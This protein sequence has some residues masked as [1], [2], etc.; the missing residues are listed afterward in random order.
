MVDCYYLLAMLY[1]ERKQMY[2]KKE[3]ESL[4]IMNCGYDLKEGCTVVFIVGIVF[5][6]KC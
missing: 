1:S 3:I 2:K 4:L 5:V 6:G